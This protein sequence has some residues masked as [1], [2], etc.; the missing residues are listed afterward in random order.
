MS[1]LVN[2][3]ELPS[4]VTCRRQWWTE[5]GRRWRWWT[6]CHQLFDG[7]SGV[8]TECDDTAP[9]SLGQ[10]KQTHHATHWSHI[11]VLQLRLVSARGPKNRRS[12]SH[13]GPYRLHETLYL[14]FL[15]YIFCNMHVWRIN[16]EQTVFLCRKALGFIRLPKSFDRA[17]VLWHFCRLVSYCDQNTRVRP[18]FIDFQ[19]HNFRMKCRLTHRNVCRSL[20]TLPTC[21][22]DSASIMSVVL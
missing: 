8:A 1:G 14:S 7:N 3:P 13:D 15:C 9:V 19:G 11:V 17:P 22:N 2:I 20:S 12:A 5:D 18:N 16:N 21:A 10:G 6:A 4:C